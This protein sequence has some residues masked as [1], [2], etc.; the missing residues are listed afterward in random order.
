LKDWKAFVDG[1]LMLLDSPERC[2]VCSRM[3]KDLRCVGAASLKFQIHL[4]F[5]F[6]MCV[7]TDLETQSYVLEKV[8]AT[9]DTADSTTL[10]LKSFNQS[11]L[12]Q[13]PFKRFPLHSKLSPNNRN[14]TTVFP[15]IKAKV[16]W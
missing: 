10:D 4:S 3:W 2:S 7:K 8:W 12:D 5:R 15:R 16:I 13:T 9:V 6:S 14:Q 11:T 1:I